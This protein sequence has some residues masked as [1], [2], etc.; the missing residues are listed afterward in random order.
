MAKEV[1]RLR[2]NSSSCDTLEAD[3]LK[4]LD[5]SKHI[6]D[7]LRMSLTPSENTQNQMLEVVTRERNELVAKVNSLQREHLNATLEHNLDMKE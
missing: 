6:N 1:H 7:D 4:L 2:N 5:L 3:G